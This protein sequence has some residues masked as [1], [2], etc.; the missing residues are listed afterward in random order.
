MRN[1]R[2]AGIAAALA[3]AGTVGLGAAPATAAPNPTTTYETRAPAPITAAE[4]DQIAAQL[5]KLGAPASVVATIFNPLSV[6]WDLFGPY[7]DDW[8]PYCDIHLFLP[9]E[10]IHLFPLIDQS[11]CWTF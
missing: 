8:A 10:W 11:G 9:W 2:L 4:R 5:R 6:G 7:L 3:L 1:H